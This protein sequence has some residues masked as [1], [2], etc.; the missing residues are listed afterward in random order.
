DDPLGFGV[1]L[2]VPPVSSLPP[3]PEALYRGKRVRASGRVARFKG[4]PEMLL[5]SPDQLQVVDVGG[6]PAA[7]G[8]SPPPAAAP[9][10]AAGPP[11]APPPP[12]PPL[13]PAAPGAPPPAAAPRAAPSPPR[14]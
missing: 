5:R 14:P 10:S 9:P 4:Q 3:H 8:A 7:A 2:L 13:P 11:P 1:V 12:P 6:P